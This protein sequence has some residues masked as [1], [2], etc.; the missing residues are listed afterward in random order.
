MSVLEERVNGIDKSLEAAQKLLYETIAESAEADRK[1]R[2]QQVAYRAEYEAR[3]AEYEAD[4]KK[5]QAEYEVRQAEYEER[6]A[7]YEAQAEADRQLLA[8]LK[9]ENEAEGRKLKKQMGELSHKLGT[10][11]EDFVF[12]D[13]PRQLRL[14]AALP[15]DSPM[16]C[17]PNVRRLNPNPPKNGGRQMVEIDA[18]AESRSHVLFNET[19]NS[20]R[21]EHVTHFVD[22][23]SN[24]RTY[25]PEYQGRAMMAAMSSFS[26][27]PEVI[28]YASRQGIIVL[29][30]DDGLM[31]LQNLP[32]F[33]WKHF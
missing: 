7:K 6:Q 3:Q 9:A 8:R 26:V 12:P 29:T 23:M 18:V 2:E 21:S 30:L 25:F 27:S 17:T 24:I 28:K 22:I 19:K 16:V 20:L 11:I 1:L 10:M 31:T 15:D 5:R 33:Q 32:S 4:Y 14:L 13:L